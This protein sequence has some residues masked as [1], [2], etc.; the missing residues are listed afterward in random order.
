MQL[1]GMSRTIRDSSRMYSLEVVMLEIKRFLTLMG[2][3]LCAAVVF[4]QEFV[5]DTI[6]VDYEAQQVRERVFKDYVESASGGRIQVNLLS[7]RAIVPGGQT[8]MVEM[9]SSGALTMGNPGEGGLAIYVPNIEAVNLP[10]LVPSWQVGA[11]LMAHDSPFFRRIAADTYKNSRGRVRLLGA[12]VNSMRNLY[13]VQPVRTPRDLTRQRVTIRVQEVPLI[14]DMWNALGANAIGLPPADRYMALETNMI[15]ALEGGIASVDSV[16]G[17]EILK[18][19]TLTNHQ[20]SAEYYMIN[21]RFFQSLPPDL[22]K[23]VLEGAQKAVWAAS[24]NREY[25]DIRALENLK[26]R[27]INVI[28]LT[29]AEHAQWQRP[30]V[31]AARTYLERRVEPDFLD[32]TIREVERIV[33]ALDAEVAWAGRNH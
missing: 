22:K 9:I 13:T 4:G 19:V 15:Q 23:I 16:G 11:R 20:F 21:E 31:A 33:R 24:P 7:R 28:S 3:I 17:F 29:A 8:D 25:T 30:A 18:S 2:L 26:A 27:G 6:L 14:I 12:H 32:F 10:F 1:R 5:I